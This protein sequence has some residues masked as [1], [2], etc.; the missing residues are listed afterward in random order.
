MEDHTTGDRPQPE[1]IHLSPPHMTD[2]ERQALL[3]AFDSNW[4]APTGPALADFEA[5]IA[6]RA[7][8]EAALAVTSGTSALHLGLRVLGVVRGDT[9]IVPTLTFVASANAVR[10]CGA[11][12]YFVDAD[13]HSGNIDPA[14]LADTLESLVSAGR[15]PAAVMTVDLY[16]NCADYDAIREIC[17]HH[18]IPVL[19]D[20]AEALGAS[21]RGRP[22]GSLGDLGVFS[23]NGNK[24]VTTG[25]GGALV[26]P[27]PF[28]DRARHLATQA[29]TE[30]LHF[31]HDELG[32]AYR[33]SNV[34]ASIGRAQLDRLDEMIGRTRELHARYVDELGDIDGLHITSQNSF[35][36][37]NGW[38]TVLTLDP[39]MHP[40]PHEV[41]ATLDEANIEA[42]PAWKPMH[43]Q[44][45]YRDSEIHGGANA[46]RH[47][48]RGLCLPS[49][50]SMTDEQ[51]TR[52][53][54]ALRAALQVD[55]VAETVDL[56]DVRDDQN[57]ASSGM[58]EQSE[59]HAAT[60]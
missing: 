29:R 16:G 39:K 46:E 32:Y 26:G 50:S 47:Y 36:R 52:V 25:G 43:L 9:V 56:D 17:D 54:G 23:F 10:Y 55:Q 57:D 48:R 14:A 49:G 30:A 27:K 22:A 42:R 58:S 2:H 8:T 37:G 53:I 12:P 51:Q 60:G 31:E 44:T 41:C 13:A 28:I 1:R 6:D 24:I 7:G 45:I 40:T 20:A 19:E 3:A 21:Y 59:D 11:V 38:L 34:L 15:T 18:D 35:G 4:I 33:M 5:T